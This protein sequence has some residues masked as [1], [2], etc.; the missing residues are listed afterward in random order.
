MK[1]LGWYSFILYS[2]LLLTNALNDDIAEIVTVKEKLIITLMLL[3]T[4]I[5][6]WYTL[7]K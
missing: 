7:V 4:L 6:L 3:P 2:V 1:V 5:Y